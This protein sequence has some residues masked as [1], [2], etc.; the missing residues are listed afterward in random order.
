[1]LILFRATLAGGFEMVAVVGGD[2]TLS[3]AAAGY[4]EPC[5]GLAVQESPRAINS[6]AALAILPAGTGDDFVR[7]RTP[8]EFR[9]MPAALRVVF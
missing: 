7:G 8:V 4:F 9:V 5:A 1:M 6:K 2:G 3:A